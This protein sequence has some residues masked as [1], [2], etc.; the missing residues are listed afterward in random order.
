[1]LEWEWYDYPNVKALFIHCLLKANHKPKTWRTV[2]VEAGE[3]ITSVDKLAK[4]TGLTPSQVR[5]CLS[6]LKASNDI[7]LAKSQQGYY[8]VISIVSWDKYQDKSQTDDKPL[9]DRWQTVSKPLANTK[10]G[11]ND[12][13]GGEERQPFADGLEKFDI[14]IPEHRAKLFDDQFVM[15]LKTELGYDKGSANLAM[16]EWIDK[17]TAEKKE[18]DTPKA[19][20]AAF[21]YYLRAEWV[22]TKYR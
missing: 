14:N 8:T 19:L 1:M 17:M 12:K 2:E 5:T 16:K 4:E 11:K 7:D 21:K 22:K 18:I 3:F 15:S 6:H 20:K 13:E 9:A 10:E